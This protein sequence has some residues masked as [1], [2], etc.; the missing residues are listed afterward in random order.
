MLTHHSQ[1]IPGGLCLEPYTLHIRKELRRGSTQD[2]LSERILYKTGFR[3]VRCTR[4]NLLEACP[5]KNR[6]QTRAGPGPSESVSITKSQKN[7]ACCFT[8]SITK[9]HRSPSVEMLSTG[10]VYSHLLSTALSPA[11]CIVH[12]RGVTGTRRKCD[13]DDRSRV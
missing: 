12:E 10:V 9:L 4:S 11:P 5:C 7:E 1:S 2:T 3:N 6:S 8:L 13:P